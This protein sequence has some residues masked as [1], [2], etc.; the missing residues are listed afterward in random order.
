[1]RVS[2]L[3]KRWEL[4]FQKLPDDQLGECDSPDTRGKQIRIDPRVS[5]ELE[6]DTIIHEI[7]HAELFQVFSEEWCEFSSS[8]LA[9]ILW[10]LGYRRISPGGDRPPSGAPG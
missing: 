3:G 10:R 6:L 7:R 9:R 5:G 2:I 8:S 4:V 1:M